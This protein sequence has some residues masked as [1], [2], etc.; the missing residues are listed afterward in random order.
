[1]LNVGSRYLGSAAAITSGVFAQGG[2]AQRCAKHLVRVRPLVM[3]VQEFGQLLAQTFVAFA[4]M[5]EQDSTLEQGLLQLLRQIA[6][7]ARDR[8]AE[9]EKIARGIFVG[10]GRWRRR[11]Y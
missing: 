5:A 3:I 8:C 11:R 9:G 6:P 1:M 10:S 2:F 4:L 7:Q